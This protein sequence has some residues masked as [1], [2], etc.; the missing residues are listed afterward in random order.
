M[1]TALTG[2][3]K[4]LCGHKLGLP[5]A[6][7]L[8]HLSPPHLSPPPLSP[9]YCNIMCYEP[10]GLWC[11]A[12]LALNLPQIDRLFLTAM[13]CRVVELIPKDN[14]K[15]IFL[16][17]DTKITNVCLNHNDA[18]RSR[19]LAPSSIKLRSNGYVSTICTLTP[20]KVCPPS[21]TIV[22]MGPHRI[23]FQTEQALVDILLPKGAEISIELISEGY[24][25]SRPIV[26]SPDVV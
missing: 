15:T 16:D 12:S 21:P 1:S 4:G 6:T 2:F 18:F 3:R 11:V 17:E 9:H 24:I 14:V 10:R 22:P 8:P 13:C 20:T 25:P 19:D 7:V 5:I 23:L 26:L